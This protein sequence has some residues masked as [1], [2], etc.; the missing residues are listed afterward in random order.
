MDERQIINYTLDEQ[1]KVNTLSTIVKLELELMERDATLYHQ[2]Q[3]L[4]AHQI[5]TNFHNLHVVNQMVL[6]KTQSG[7]T[8]LMLATIKLYIH[9]NLIPVENI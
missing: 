1:W 4:S 7:K 3:L 6:G 9:K 5:I 8:G 2:E